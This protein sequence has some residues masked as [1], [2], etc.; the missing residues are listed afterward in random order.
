MEK[1]KDL[2]IKDRIAIVSAIVAFGVGWALTVA[3][4]IV[5]PVGEISDSVL[6]VLGQSLVYAASVFGVAS[7]FTAEAVRL[8]HD[9]RKMLNDY[10]ERNMAA[11]AN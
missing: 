10:E 2:N 11:A 8:R 1:W 6:W 9:M 4:F 3:A 5:P 7:Y